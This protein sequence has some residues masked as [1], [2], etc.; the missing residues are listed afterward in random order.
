MS[1]K[2]RLERLEKNRGLNE[3]IKFFSVCYSTDSESEKE[4]KINEAYQR[5]ADSYGLT[6]EGI[7]KSKHELTNIIINVGGHGRT[8]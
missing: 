5:T 1:I 2:T 3:S 6:V 4:K 8:K 7:K